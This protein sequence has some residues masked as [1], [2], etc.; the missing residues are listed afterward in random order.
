[1]VQDLKQHYLRS[2][3]V[4]T[5]DGVIQ[6]VEHASACDRLRPQGDD[7]VRQAMLN[8]PVQ[9]ALVTVSLTILPSHGFSPAL[10]EPALQVSYPTVDC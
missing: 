9:K 2:I 6:E 4:D 1:M 10:T 3:Q 5:V 7:C 8:H